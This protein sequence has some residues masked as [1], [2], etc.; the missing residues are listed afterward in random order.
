ME[1]C[2]SFKLEEQEIELSDNLEAL[3]EGVL[4]GSLAG[5][6]S[7][8][9]PYFLNIVLKNSPSHCHRDIQIAL[10]CLC[11]YSSGDF[12][13]E[14]L[15]LEEHQLLSLL[16]CFDQ[17]KAAE[18]ILLLAYL[19]SFLLENATMRQVV[20]SGSS[21]AIL[22]V[23]CLKLEMISDD[24]TMISPESAKLFIFHTT[25]SNSLVSH[26]VLMSLARFAFS[27]D[28]DLQG[29]TVAATA[30]LLYTAGPEPSQ[31]HTTARESVSNV[32]VSILQSLCVRAAQVP[33][34][35]CTWR[36]CKSVLLD[37][38]TVSKDCRNSI[39][40]S[41]MELASGF[42]VLMHCSATSNAFGRESVE[43][44]V[45]EPETRE[46]DFMG[47]NLGKCNMLPRDVRII[48]R[49][50]EASISPQFQWH[51]QSSIV[52]A[53]CQGLRGVIEG[54]WADAPEGGLELE[55]DAGPR[56]V[57]ALCRFIHT[58]CATISTLDTESHLEVIKLASDLGLECLLKHGI[59]QLGEEA[60][61][62]QSGHLVTRACSFAELYDI[63][64]LRVACDLWRTRSE[65]LDHFGRK[66]SSTHSRSL[67]TAPSEG[68]QVNGDV[69]S[70]D[71]DAFESKMR[72][73]SMPHLGTQAAYEIDPSIYSFASKETNLQPAKPTAKVNGTSGRKSADVKSGGIYKL[74]LQEQS[75]PSLLEELALRPG[76]GMSAGTIKTPR[77][78]SKLPRSKSRSKS[79]TEQRGAAEAIEFTGQISLIPNPAP[80]DAELRYTTI[81]CVF[82]RIFE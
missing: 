60:A 58:G 76:P 47:Q 69:S 80:T 61:T 3:L 35:V 22:S 49:V 66:E 48:P 15:F 31:S 55:I 56:A 6:A 82:H 33:S 26:G 28:C 2:S 23:L 9:W 1:I 77:S 78:A 45:L 74:L 43:D 57:E 32:L 12:G 75:A 17:W 7:S 52:W 39:F 59:S 14:P 10:R 20:L 24:N 50:T 42:S 34:L 21:P 5:N 27:T 64:D 63:D 46:D 11:S 36:M 29:A 18:S 65:P 25:S 73:L 72:A 41:W 51:L 40:D 70:F 4:D 54:F 19:I 62:S 16:H 30:R 38:A 71:V 79:Y 44:S 13:L 37:W 81:M 8:L 68:S 53:R 67:S